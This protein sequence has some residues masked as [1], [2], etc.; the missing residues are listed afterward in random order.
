MV[1][2]EVK[3]TFN[4]EFIN[5]VD[6][7]IVF[8]ALVGRRPAQDP[9]PADGAAQRQPDRPPDADRAGAGSGGLDHRCH[10]QGPLVWRPAAAPRDPA[11]YRGSAGRRADS[12]PSCR[13]AISRSISRRARSPIGRPGSRSVP[14]AVSRATSDPSPVAVYAAGRH[15]LSTSDRSSS[16]SGLAV[17]SGFGPSARPTVVRLSHDLERVCV[18]PHFGARALGSGRGFGAARR[19]TPAPAPPAQPGARGRQAPLSATPAQ[20]G[21]CLRPGPSR[22][23]RISPCVFDP[24][25]ESIIEAQT[26]LYYI[27]A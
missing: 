4:P 10:L 23:S 8:D 26:Y 19:Q 12:R 15:E 6:E 13:A 14:A 22:S 16:E 27:Q 24:V 25:N 20:A 11:L 7:L 3:R 9:Q 18:C 1:L 17:R 2:G 21:A 5:R